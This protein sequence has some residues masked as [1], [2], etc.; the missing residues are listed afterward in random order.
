MGRLLH[1]HDRWKRRT[2]AA[3]RTPSLSEQVA[4][5]AG[6]SRVAFDATELAGR[7]DRALLRSP[8][9][10]AP[11]ALETLRALSHDGVPLGVVS[12]V[13]NESSSA[14]RELLDRAGLLRWFRVVY[15]SSDHEFAKPRAEPFRTVAQFLGVLPSQLLHVGDLRYDLLGVHRAGGAGWLFDGYARLNRYLPGHV[16]QRSPAR[17]PRVAS[18]PEL[19]RKWPAAATGE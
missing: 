19:L 10:T 11:G 17:A 16:S 4:W 18:W 2:E 12:N 6:R 3:G 14:A 1:E 8:V 5:L 15:L 13:L 7:L 9:R